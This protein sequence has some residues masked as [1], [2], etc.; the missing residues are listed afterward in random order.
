MLAPLRDQRRSGAN[1]DLRFGAILG[2][3]RA[4]TIIGMRV[5]G[6]DAYAKGWIGVELYHGAFVAAHIADH[7]TTLLSAVNDIPAVGID[8]PL[9]L[10]ETGQRQA[11]LAARAFLGIHLGSAVFSVPPR[12]VWKQEYTWHR[13]VRGSEYRG[14]ACVPS[15]ES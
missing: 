14:Y 7:L 1:T 3:A 11:D 9:G 5:L 15:A 8:M 6:V 10:V 2:Y 12:A 4:G 13:R